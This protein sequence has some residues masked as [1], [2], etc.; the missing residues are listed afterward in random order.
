MRLSQ[1]L[2]QHNISEEKAEI[3]F[4]IMGQ[5]FTSINKK[6][7]E[8]EINEFIQVHKSFG[9]KK[10]ELVNNQKVVYKDDYPEDFLN[11]NLFE[12][13]INQIIEGKTEFNKS[14]IHKLEFES[15][16][17][18]SFLTDF[19]AFSICN[20]LKNTLAKQI[21]KLYFSGEFSHRIQFEAHRLAIETIDKYG[22]SL[23]HHLITLPKLPF[24]TKSAIPVFTQLEKKKNLSDNPSFRLLFLNEKVQFSF[25]SVMV[26]ETKIVFNNVILA[27]SKTNNQNLFLI[28]K[29]GKCLPLSKDRNLGP[30]IQ[31]F[32]SQTNNLTDAILHYGLQTG[33]CSVCGRPLSDPESIRLG[34]G[35]VCREYVNFN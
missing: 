15:E 34:I 4:K 26:G 5:P 16:Q 24:N 14:E 28:G 1:L 18:E 33:E 2:K 9:K 30:M 17:I 7:D 29:N 8:D 25:Y 23:I 10:V 13:D 20:G 6:L 27:K 21:C 12:K 11:H 32:L 35:P 22:E 19:E 3:Y 31:V